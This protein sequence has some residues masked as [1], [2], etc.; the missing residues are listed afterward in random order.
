[1]TPTSIRHRYVI[2]LAWAALALVTNPVWH[3]VGHTF[4]DHHSEATGHLCDV[5]WTEQDLCPYCDAVSHF[6]E[7]PDTEVRTGL[8]VHLWT[9]ES[10]IFLPTDR[11]HL[12][13]TRLRA[14]PVLA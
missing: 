14:P 3:A 12:F 5:Q 8:L 11:R 7:M 13:S 9:I 4:S 10:H 2:L 6:A 1:M